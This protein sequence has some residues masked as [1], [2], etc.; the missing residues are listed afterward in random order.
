MQKH[1]VAA[2]LVVSFIAPVMAAET[3]YIIFDNTLKGCTIAT[4]EPTDKTH[5]KVLGTYK[6]EAEAEKA[7]ASM[8]EC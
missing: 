8:K 7:I 3:F 1:L 4:A 6:S 5:Y 2:A